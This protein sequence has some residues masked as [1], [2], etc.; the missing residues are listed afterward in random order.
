M[1]QPYSDEELAPLRHTR[2]RAPCCQPC[3]PR[4]LATID[5]LKT[6]LVEA[7]YC[8][9]ADGT[10]ARSAQRLVEIKEL[11]RL[12]ECEARQTAEQIERAR[13]AEKHVQ[14]LEHQVGCLKRGNTRLQALYDSLKAQDAKKET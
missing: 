13:K 6:Q 8:N 3:A 5:E 11:H 10:L 9:T 2:A 7:R 12:R 14:E 1:A 4:F